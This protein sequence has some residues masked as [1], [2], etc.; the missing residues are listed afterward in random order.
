VFKSYIALV[1]GQL[2]KDR[3]EIDQ[4]IARDP[5]HRIRMAV[6][7]SGPLGVEPVSRPAKIWSLHSP[8]C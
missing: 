2:E 3:G 1:H 8:G 4:P 5:R 7:R 6:V